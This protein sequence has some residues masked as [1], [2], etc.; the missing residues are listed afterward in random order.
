MTFG[1]QRTPHRG[2]REQHI[3][4][5]DGLVRWTGIRRIVV[6]QGL[7]LTMA[8][9]VRR[10]G[11]VEEGGVL[12]GYIRRRSVP[13]V[14]P[15]GRGEDTSL[16]DS[17]DLVVVDQ[18]VSGLNAQKT[19]V[20]LHSDHDSQEY[21]FRRLEHVEPDIQHLG[22]WHSDHCNGLDTL[23][24]GDLQSYYAIVNSRNHAHRFY[25]AILWTRLPEFLVPNHHG[26]PVLTNRADRDMLQ[27][28]RFFLIMRG[29][30]GIHVLNPMLVGIENITELS[31]E[32]LIEELTEDE[33]ARRMSYG[34]GR[35]ERPTKEDVTGG[36]WYK[37]PAARRI[38]G[39]DTVL[40]KDLARESQLGF[41][42]RD[43]IDHGR[44][45]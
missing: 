5:R 25:L 32:K 38:F 12:L 16:R 43:K 44:L 41:T 15:M 17:A 40:F 3:T 14:T 13:Y 45:V 11:G 4:S 2:L 34:Q 26:D 8:K 30:Q 9:Y 21:V 22:S 23:N 19:A 28:V 42:Y 24:G 33:Y 18:V 20:S 36:P 39:A 29:R 10:A 31:Y 27:C 1:S 6:R 37:R 7:F 35:E